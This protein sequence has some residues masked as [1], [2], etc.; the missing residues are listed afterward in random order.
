MFVF[1][2]VFQSR[3]FRGNCC[4]GYRYISSRIIYCSLK[5]EKVEICLFKYGGKCERN[6]FEGCIDF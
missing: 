5:L 2:L 3:V 6:G 4:F 1:D